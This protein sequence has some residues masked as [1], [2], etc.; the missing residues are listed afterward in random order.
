MGFVYAGFLLST[1]SHSGIYIVI[2]LHNAVLSST[3]GR[4]EVIKFHTIGNLK[5]S[6]VK[7]KLL[8]AKCKIYEQVIIRSFKF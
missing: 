5:F 8:V 7:S 2:E 6:G 3:N 4:Q 1:V